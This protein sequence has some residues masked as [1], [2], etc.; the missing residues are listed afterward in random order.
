M[1]KS[2]CLIKKAAALLFTVAVAAV[3][4]AGCGDTL[5]K[6]T[7]AYSREESL[8]EIDAYWNEIKPSYVQAPLDIYDDADESVTLADISTF[9]IVVEGKGQIDIEV[10]A[11]T[12]MSSKAPDDWMVEAAEKFNSKRNQVGGKTV[13]VS[14]RKITS[15]EAVT[16][17]EDGGYRPDVFAP[18]N[19]AWGDMLEAKGFKKVTLA[20]RV[21]GNTAGI[22][23]EKNTYET[24]KSKY[25]D[26]TVDKVLEASLAGDLT[27]A[28]TNP[29]TSSTGLNILAAMLK[30]FD[31]AD[32]LSDAA[33]GKLLDYQ[34]QSPPVA[35]TTSVLR[36]QAAKGIIKA[37]VMEEQA[38]RN[39]P[40]LKSYVYTP[41]GIRH[42]HP[43]YTFDYVDSEK[44]EAA[45]LFTEFLKSSD[46]QNLATKKGFNLHDDYK[47]QDPGLDGAGWISAQKIW[48]ASKD[49]GRPI[50]AVFVSDVSGSMD[51]LPI[52]SLKES[53]N[54]ASKYIGSDNYIGLVSYNDR[55][56]IDLPIEQFDAT[57]RAY[58]SG[59]VKQ[60]TA[61]GGTATY[62]AVLVGLKLIEDK[63]EEVPDAKPMLFVLSDGDA[64]RGVNL[65]RTTKIVGGLDVPVYSI[66]Y[67]L[68]GGSAED[69][70]R[71]LSSV[72]EAALINAGS[73]D[74]V[75]QLRNL[76]N[77][78]L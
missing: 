30:A 74:I 63:M 33:A 2:D 68:S 11:A 44:Q 25:G 24:F 20:E 72:N 18:S 66:G 46:M 65:D 15:G 16:Y 70:L 77:V 39:T 12:E 37:M 14:V 19:S 26:V 53:L 41:A 76:F 7:E 56:Y 10:A 28:Y 17:M 52:N 22:L 40:E 35:Y 31:P 48:K 62:D 78:Q 29:Y 51:G 32:P 43:L 9:P 21:A 23:M 73:D 13:S 57:Q 1:K 27:F 34:K 38:Y 6:E 54:S 47:T 36:E 42:D 75:N 50:I 4:L 49:G 60:L 69:Q 55:V 8:K 61:S 45:K 5:G 64:N 58:F 67:N 71:K 3:S 59:A